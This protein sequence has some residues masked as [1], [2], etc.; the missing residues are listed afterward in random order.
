[1]ST[2]YPSYHLRFSVSPRR[3]HLLRASNLVVS[4]L[5]CTG[6][7]IYS[8]KHKTLP[9]PLPEGFG[10]PPS[11]GIAFLSHSPEI[12][13]NEQR[14]SPPPVWLSPAQDAAY[15]ASASLH[16]GSGS[17]DVP[18]PTQQFGRRGKNATAHIE[19]A[20]HPFWFPWPTMRQ[21]SILPSCFCQW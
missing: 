15:L 8:T 16:F 14:Q 2:F 6:Q 12:S 7:Q 17:T 13:P 3:V 4:R 9:S 20:R 18:T 5:A 1:M 19:Y 21:M 11:A 10:P